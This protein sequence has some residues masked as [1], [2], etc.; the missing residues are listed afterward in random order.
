MMQTLVVS[1]NADITA[2][3]LPETSPD[4]YLSTENVNLN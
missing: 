4:F 1:Q 3:R 2:L